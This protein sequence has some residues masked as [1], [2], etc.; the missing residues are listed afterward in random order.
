MKSHQINENFSLFFSNPYNVKLTFIGCQ[1]NGFLEI[2]IFNHIKF[3]ISHVKNSF[4]GQPVLLLTYAI[5]DF[6]AIAGLP[7]LIKFQ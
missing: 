5:P 7:I 6:F 3:I 2:H 4:F 1:K